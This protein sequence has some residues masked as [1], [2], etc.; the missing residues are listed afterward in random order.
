MARGRP[1]QHASAKERFQ[2]YRD[3]MKKAGYRRLTFEVPQEF[4]AIFDRLCKKHDVT[5]REM[6]CI[7]VAHYEEDD[8]VRECGKNEDA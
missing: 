1:K 3:R 7:L 8:G 6:F 4:K 2:A 5:A